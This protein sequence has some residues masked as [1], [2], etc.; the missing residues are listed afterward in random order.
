MLL[1]LKIVNW[2]KNFEKRNVKLK[3]HWVIHFSP[4]NDNKFG[5][6]KGIMTYE[7]ALGEIFPYTNPPSTVLQSE[8]NKNVSQNCEIP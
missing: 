7:N 1:I 6:I 4:P 5:L 3:P 8:R 2:K